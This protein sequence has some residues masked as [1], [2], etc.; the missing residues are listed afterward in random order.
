MSVDLKVNKLIFIFTHES[1]TDTDFKGGRNL[2]QIRSSV[3]LLLLFF[4]IIII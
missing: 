1:L 3:L 4:I 2:N